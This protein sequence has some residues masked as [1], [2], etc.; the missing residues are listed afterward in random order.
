MPSF[1]LKMRR[2]SLPPSTSTA[3]PQQVQ[4][5]Q[6]TAPDAEDAGKRRHRSQIYAPT[7]VAIPFPKR[8]S[9]GQPQDAGSFFNAMLP[10][11]I[12]PLHPSRRKN[13]SEE[14]QLKRHG[15][16][17]LQ[18]S[19][20]REQENMPP[21]PAPFSYYTGSPSGTFGHPTIREKTM[22]KLKNA[23][24]LPQNEY[25]TRS[26]ASSHSDRYTQ[27]E[28]PTSAFYSL[29]NSSSSA[30]VPAYA[31]TTPSPSNTFGPRTPVQSSGSG[32]RI[33]ANDIFFSHL[34]TP[35]PLPPLDHPAFVHASKNRIP[36]SQSSE[37][38][39]RS[40]GRV[41]NEKEPRHSRSLPSIRRAARNSSSRA[42]PTRPRRKGSKS[43]FLSRLEEQL[44]VIESTKKGHTRSQSKGSLNSNLSRRSSAEFS[45]KQV[46]LL[47]VSGKSSESWE[48]QVSKEL[49]RL[50][51]AQDV[52]KGGGGHVS[53]RG[54]NLP[55]GESGV[56]QDL[57]PPFS[58][59]DTSSPNQ[60]RSHY[61]AA[62]VGK[63]AQSRIP[64]AIDSAISISSMSG[65]HGAS[66]SKGILN[67]SAGRLR[68]KTNSNA[69]RRDGRPKFSSERTRTPSP[70]PPKLTTFS[71]VAGPEQASSSLLVPP[72]LSFTAATPEASPISPKRTHHKSTPTQPNSAIRSTSPPPAIQKSFSSASTKRKADEA[73]VDS[74]TPPREHR[75]TFA[76]EPRTH[77]ASAASG[78]SHAPSSF[79]RSKR[80]RISL[81]SDNHGS[82]RSAL[83]SL[84]DSPNA[85]S[86]GSMSSKHSKTSASHTGHHQH[87]SSR[88]PSTRDG[89]GA[90]S[91]PHTGRPS[92][93]R[94]LS[95]ASIP[96]SAFMA[97]HAPSI[98]RSSAF[99]MRDPRK[100]P[101]IQDTPWTL[102][103]P[104][105]SQEG[106][107]R[108]AFDGWTD[109][110]GSP[111]HAW[112]F[113]IGFIIFPL[114]W[115]A[116][117]V[118]PILRT[119]RLESGDTEKGVVLDDPQVEHDYKSWRR[120]CRIMAGVSIVTYIP[121]IVL[122]AIY[123]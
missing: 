81:P 30:I 76:P 111:L 99:H 105:G 108:W 34:E 23:G 15:G 102:S 53:A 43:S 28:T 104:D 123:A 106:R 122:V 116:G 68:P 115:L 61:R 27:V 100:P 63:A 60:G 98:S 92:S 19:H 40:Q 5:A 103:F 56:V 3:E 80:A 107:S 83:P 110:G 9:F 29:H 112:L 59:Q 13:R 58:F 65:S 11:R 10:P 20:P 120:R 35:P 67:P 32:R 18:G 12:T 85:K 42:S 38:G 7:D 26:R 46:S 48:V 57:G 84:G 14:R 73:E 62:A 79:H 49:L 50:S 2:A 114:W 72:A 22:A 95:Q 86:T 24:L 82:V 74:H 6:V 119:R 25:Q 52:V 77:R 51:L 75:T 87:R 16:L 109:R 33:R 89:H 118:I 17:E 45:A 54:N 93:R 94:S 121:F 44:K 47:G 88:P 96:I 31:Q 21:H 64:P 117:F 66:S 113:F 101:R 55:C 4:V 1:F 97:P 91:S 36:G 71:A 39:A 69:S 78:S 37:R 41:P 8:Y 70:P 90:G